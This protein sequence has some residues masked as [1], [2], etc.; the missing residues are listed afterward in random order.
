MTI[1]ESIK[2]DSDTTREKMPMLGA[3]D[4][5]GSRKI[6]P[7]EGVVQDWLFVSL[8]VPLFTQAPK[9]R[10]LAMSAVGTWFHEGAR[11]MWVLNVNHLP[12]GALFSLPFFGKGSLYSQPTKNRMPFFPWPLGI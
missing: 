4:H 2:D 5:S 3:H 8:A 9:T 12:S 1:R 10:G 6:D 7:P 11:A